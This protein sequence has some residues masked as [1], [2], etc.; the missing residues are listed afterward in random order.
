MIIEET[1]DGIISVTRETSGEEVGI[2]DAETIV[3]TIDIAQMMLKGE[4]SP[5]ERWNKE[6]DSRATKYEAAPAYKQPART[7]SGPRY[8]YVPGQARSSLGP[9]SLEKLL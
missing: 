5:G 8:H 9:L 3:E 4:K 6:V 1:E 7:W 2:Q